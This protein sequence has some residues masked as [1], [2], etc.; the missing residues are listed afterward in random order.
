MS[1]PVTSFQEFFGVRDIMDRMLGYLQTGDNL[2]IF[3]VYPAACCG[4]KVRRFKLGWPRKLCASTEQ[5][6]G[7]VNHA[8][9]L[10]AGCTDA[11]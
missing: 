8:P 6:G 4:E 1:D 9:L 10:A 11:I 5:Q 3:S 2:L 7:G